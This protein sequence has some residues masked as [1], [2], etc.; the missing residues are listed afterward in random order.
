M[1]L[2]EWSARIAFLGF[3]SVVVVAGAKAQTLPRV[4]FP[5]D[6][7]HLNDV[8]TGKPSD[9]LQ[10]IMSAISKPFQDLADFVNSDAA[11]AA[12]LAT[13]VPG[14]QDTNGQACWLKMQDAGAVFKA[15]PVPITLKI[16]TDFE[17]IRLLNMTA[18]N[19]CSYAPC[20]VVFA[21]AA[22]LV[23]SVSSAVGGV[24]TSGIQIPSLTTL[25]ARIPQISPMLPDAAT[26]LSKM[27]TATATVT[28]VATPSA[29]EAIP[30]PAKQP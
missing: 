18:N 8:G 21:D 1:K 17:A 12:A 11:G 2:L 22:N 14:L 20:T 13:V 28:P 10:T 15:H 19:L 27:T 26:G 9:P 24:I 23:T 30:P 6:P 25:C 7:L 29:P 3:L 5:I 4:K 16:M